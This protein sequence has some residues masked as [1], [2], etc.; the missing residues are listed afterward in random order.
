MWASRSR[1]VRAP[2]CPACAWGR[3]R[4]DGAPRDEAVPRPV[5]YPP[6]GPLAVKSSPASPALLRVHGRCIQVRPPVTTRDVSGTLVA[7]LPLSPEEGTNSL[8]SRSG[9]REM[10]RGDDVMKPRQPCW[11]APA[12]LTLV[13]AGRPTVAPPPQGLLN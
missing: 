12:V 8:G 13:L 3:S 2:P 1:R 11:W 9:H 4:P 7:S 10:P 5:C 6:G